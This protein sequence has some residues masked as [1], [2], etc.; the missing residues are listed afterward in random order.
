[1]TQTSRIH[2]W[3]MTRMRHH[4]SKF[5]T[6]LVRPWNMT[7]PNF[8]HDALTRKHDTDITHSYVRHDTDPTQ[9][10]TVRACDMTHPHLRHDALTRIYDA[11]TTHS[12]GGHDTFHQHFFGG[13]DSNAIITSKSMAL[14]I[15]LW[16]MKH[17]S[18]I[19][20]WDM[21]PMR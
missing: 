17:F 5:V 20:L 9:H 18:F 13:H 14:L 4:T 1:M 2:M 15:H 7:H 16:D 8:R 6:L 19:H 12:Y 21:T 3:D 11:D 10:I